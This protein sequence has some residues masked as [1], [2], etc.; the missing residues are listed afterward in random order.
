M[1]LN[2]PQCSSISSHTS[3]PLSPSLN[4]SIL[5]TQLPASIQP[6]FHFDT[7]SLPQLLTTLPLRPSSKGF[8]YTLQEQRNSNPHSHSAITFDPDLSWRLVRI[9]IVGAAICLFPLTHCHALQQGQPWFRVGAGA[10]R[11]GRCFQGCYPDSHQMY[12]PPSAGAQGC[13]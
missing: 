3:I 2:V 12:H 9:T 7:S 13:S 11:Q 1:F 6:Y 5:R 8:R 10:I 4:H